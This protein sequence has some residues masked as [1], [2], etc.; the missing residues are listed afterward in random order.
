MTSGTYSTRS[1]ADNMGIVPGARPRPGYV[2]TGA[3]NHAFS[4][5]MLNSFSFS[6]S[7]NVIVATPN[8][9]IMKRSTLGLTFPEINPEN[10]FGVGPN[11]SIAGFTGYN[12]GDML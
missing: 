5:T 10:H 3:L 2:T 1:K 7:H 8:N 6:F 12:A 11:V 9:D 4:P